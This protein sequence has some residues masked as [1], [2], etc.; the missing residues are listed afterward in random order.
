MTM[1]WIFVVS[2][3]MLIAVMYL[4]LIR[5]KRPG[6][7][8][9]PFEE[10]LIAHRGLFRDGIPE[11]SLSAFRLAVDHGFGIELDVQLTADGRLVVFHDRTLDRM[12]G[13]GTLIS[14]ATYEELEKYPLSGGEEKIPLFSDVLDAVGGKV[15]LII[16]VKS[17]GDHIGACRELIKQLGAYEGDYCVESFNPSVLKY[18]KRHAP[19]VVRGQL[20]ENYLRSGALRFPANVLMGSLLLNFIGRPSFIAYNRTDRKN[21]AMKILKRTNSAKFAAWT[22]RSA[23]GSERIL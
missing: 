5:T 23:Q 22:V 10:R 7:R 20:S 21:L 13:N 4:F 15:P 3:P 9:K 6:K 8:L 19:D 14:S 2:I 16:E 12:C 18:F 1:A 11:N 17:H